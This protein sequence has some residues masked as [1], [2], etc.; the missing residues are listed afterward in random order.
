MA[1]NFIDE[2]EEI[3]KEDVEE[4]VEE[5]E[6]H[7]V[8]IIADGHVVTGALLD[9]ITTEKKSDFDYLVGVDSD[10]LIYHPANLSGIDYSPYFYFGVS[11]PVTIYPRNAS[12]LKW[13]DRSGRVHY[14]THVTIPPR[15][16]DKFLDR[17]VARMSDSD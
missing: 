5:L 3:V 4:R 17:A 9:S 15:K 1:I 7:M 14:A 10:A 11:R 8:D 2:F 12:Y 6:N 16:A 13:T